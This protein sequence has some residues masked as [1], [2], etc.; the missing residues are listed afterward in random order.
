MALREMRFKSVYVK[1]TK[2]G[3][4]VHRLTSSTCRIDWLDVDTG[5]WTTYE[6][7][8]DSDG[9]V[10]VNAEDEPAAMLKATG[11][12]VFLPTFR[13]IEGGFGISSEAQG[14][15]S[16]LARATAEVEDSLAAISRRLTS[17]QHAFVCSISTVDIVSLLARQ[18]SLLSESSNVIQQSVTQ[19]VIHRIKGYR[20][21]DGQHDPLANANE[22]IDEVLQMVTMMEAQREEIMTPVEV[23]RSL[24]QQLFRHSGIKMSDRLSFG[25]AA[26]A[27]NSNALSAGEKQMLSFICYNAFYSNALIIID[28][29]ELSL[30]VDWQ[31]QL[32]AILQSQQASNQFIIATHSPFIY[33]KYED[34]EIV[35]D[36]DRGDLADA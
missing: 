21:A 33:S 14:A 34:K 12:S 19:K 9:D 13:R 26:G 24:V 31:R 2:Y 20:S 29:P 10:V 22:V 25:D 4:R 27:I 1:T 16:R 36:A 6:D 11:A 3:C 30:H 35:I 28:E 23:V 32:F 7:L 15:S 5:E 8:I 18:I 17:E